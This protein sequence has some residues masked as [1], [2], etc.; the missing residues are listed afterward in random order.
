MIAFAPCSI[1]NTLSSYGQYEA[2]N[3]VS[4][5]LQTISKS[6]K[7]VPVMLMGKVLNKKKYKW[8]EYLEAVM[9]S[10]GVS[11]FALDTASAASG[12]S[13]ELKGI[14]CL[15]LYIIA[16]SFTSQ[17]QSRVYR[18]H[19]GVDQYQ[20]MFAVN[21]W[22]ILFTLGGL[23]ANSEFFS[24]L[25]FL[26]ENPPAIWD[27]VLISVTSATGQLFIY[28]TIKKF[29]PVVFTIIMTTRQVFSM[30]LSTI[31]YRHPM[32]P[33]ALLGASVVFGTIFYRIHRGQRQK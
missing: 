31:Y 10:A 28:Y 12:G 5:P 8:V 26:Q 27:Q 32:T 16:D 22:S 33:I 15:A 19:K 30:V 21:V 14:A 4:F 23:L 11:V 3:Y 17:W 1:S 13:T 7:V 2:L 9:I 29:G 20:M 18:E 6:T 25:T 24:T